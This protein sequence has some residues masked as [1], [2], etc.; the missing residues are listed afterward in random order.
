MIRTQITLDRELRNRARKR[1]AE[2]GISLAEYIRRLLAR[3]LSGSQPRSDPSIVFDLGDSGGSDVASY[4][5]EMVGEAAWAGRVDR[6][7][8]AIGSTD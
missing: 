7:P 5:D 3:D 2:L 1:A 6:P 8:R 4:K